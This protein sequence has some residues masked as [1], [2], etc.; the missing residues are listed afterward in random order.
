MSFKDQ[1]D[2]MFDLD[3]EHNSQAIRMVAMCTYYFNLTLLIIA[4]F[5]ALVYMFVDGGEFIWI[6]LIILGSCLVEYLGVTAITTLIMGKASS[7]KELHYIRLYVMSIEKQLLKIEEQNSSQTDKQADSNTKENQVQKDINHNKSTT[8]IT[9]IQEEKKQSK[10]YNTSP[11]ETKSTTNKH[12]PKK[13]EVIPDTPIHPKVTLQKT[14][15]Y[16]SFALTFQSD[17]DMILF[18]QSTN[19]S[20]IREILNNPPQS[21]RTIVQE[22]VNK[23]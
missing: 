13:T 23:L 20:T 10:A 18:L 3:T 21:I 14:Q 7:L 2:A 17:N 6:S 1:H 22:Y 19:D 12:I 5:V 16:L 9:P 15:D 11:N 4:M 8:I